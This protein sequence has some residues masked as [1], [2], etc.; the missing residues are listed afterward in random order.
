MREISSHIRFHGPL[1]IKEFMTV[2]LTHPKHGYYMRRDVFGRA[3][4]FITSPEV[5]QAF[6]E[7]LGVW[8]I[9]SW[10]QLGSPPAVRLVELGPG[11]GTLMADLL[12][13]TAV[14]H[15][16]H[17]A[18]SVHLVEVSPHLR[19]LQREIL[20]GPAATQIARAAGSNEADDA[21]PSAWVGGDD[22]SAVPVSWHLSLDLVPSDCPLLVIGHEFLDALPV[23]QFV[24]TERGWRERMVDLSVHLA[25]RTPTAEDAALQASIA[26]VQAPGTATRPVDAG[27]AEEAGEAA[28]GVRDL[29]ED[30]RHLDFVLSA[31]P[32]PASALLTNELPLGL[33]Q[34]EVC[35]IAQALIQQ[36]ARRLA[37][38]RGA[39]LFVDYGDDTTPADSLRGIRNHRF[40][41]PLHAPGAADLSV[42]IDFATLRRVALTEA[43]ELRC[44]PLM[45]QRDFLAAMGLEARINALLRRTETAEQRRA[46]IQAAGRLVQVPGMG[47]AYKVFALAHAD[48]AAEA[49]PGFPPCERSDQYLDWTGRSK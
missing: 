24:R 21:P 47:S 16:F 27:Q 11:R 35:P 45:L 39:A 30:E 13:S 2:A 18:L 34:A 3:G 36:L 46:L 44:P 14:F 28:D 7:L 1:S 5:S 12:R 31:T 42:D 26:A 15:E 17:E 41:H 49:V 37:D 38:S 6:G 40:V 8:C 32:T 20:C 4:D 48:I 22:A 33:A 10:Q 9:A 25:A 43:P 19:D 23:H 29:D